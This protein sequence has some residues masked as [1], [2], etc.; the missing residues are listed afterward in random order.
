MGDIHAS[1]VLEIPEWV[2][3]QETVWAQELEN[4]KLLD[5]EWRMMSYRVNEDI[6]LSLP[7]HVL[8][9]TCIPQKATMSG[10]ESNAAQ[11]Y[12]LQR[13]RYLS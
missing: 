8:S 13:F 3:G 6:V 11:A 4:N 2:M 10:R 12:T 9:E 1:V 7:S 5:T